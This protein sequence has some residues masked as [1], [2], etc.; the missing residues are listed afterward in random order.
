MD[1]VWISKK[2]FFITVLLLCINFSCS[3]Q[4][5]TEDIITSKTLSTT[6]RLYIEGTKA[7]IMQETKATRSFHFNF[8]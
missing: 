6:F 8:E 1:K 3:N 2:V 4:Y 5:V 7:E